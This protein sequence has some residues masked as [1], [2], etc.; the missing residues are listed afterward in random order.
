ML[1]EV[2]AVPLAIAD[3][4]RFFLGIF[5]CFFGGLALGLH[6]DEFGVGGEVVEGVAFEVGES[7]EAFAFHKF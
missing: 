3:D 2:V 1:D 4:H 7:V 6:A 5:G